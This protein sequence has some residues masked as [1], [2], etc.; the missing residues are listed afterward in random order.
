MQ[1]HGHV[2][3]LSVYDMGNFN[4]FY[5]GN[6]CMDAWY[7]CG[8]VFVIEIT[9]KV[10]LDTVWLLL[11]GNNNWYCVLWKEDNNQWDVPR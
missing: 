3:L 2:K 4:I 1:K 6:L 8:Y 11:E 9:S 7:R 10:L 5:I